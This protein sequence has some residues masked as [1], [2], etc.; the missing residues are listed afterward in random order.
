MACGEASVDSTFAPEG[1][2]ESVLLAQTI[3]ESEPV[4]ETETE[5]ETVTETDTETEVEPQSEPDTQSEPLVTNV[6][7]TAST[8][9]VTD[10][11]LVTC[12]L[13]T[14]PSPRDRG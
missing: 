5:S 10:L 4:P 7:F 6:P 11:V 3:P 12:L 14:S 9:D 1:V 2:D 8:E 13:Y